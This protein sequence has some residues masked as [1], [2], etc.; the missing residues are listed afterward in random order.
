MS[1]ITATEVGDDELSAQLAIK[2]RLVKNSSAFVALVAMRIFLFLMIFTMRIRLTG[3][4]DETVIDFGTLYVC[5]YYVK[6]ELTSFKCP[7]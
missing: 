3:E 7:T 6:N 1:P 2:H 4:C 5:T